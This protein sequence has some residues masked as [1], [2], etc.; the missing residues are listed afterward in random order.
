MNG[1]TNFF[2]P[3]RNALRLINESRFK[4][5]DIVFVTDGEANLPD[6]FIEKFNDTKTQ[7][8]F[9]CLSVLIGNGKRSTVNSFSDKIVR[10]NNFT[11]AGEAFEI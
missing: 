8:K 1:G 2:D 11:E 9:E 6:E 5:A 4:N 3:L 7:K 10:A